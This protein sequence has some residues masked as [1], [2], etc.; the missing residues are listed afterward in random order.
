MSETCFY[1]STCATGGFGC[2]AGGEGAL[3]RFCGHDDYVPCPDASAREAALAESVRSRLQAEVGRVQAEA[4]DPL[5]A[6]EVQVQVEVVHASTYVVSVGT[7]GATTDAARTAA[8][9][10]AGAALLC[11]SSHT[12]ADSSCRVGVMQ[13]FSDAADN[14]ACGAHSACAVLGLTGECCP[15]NAEGAACCGSSNGR[16]RHLDESA[17]SPPL[18]ISRSSSVPL[19][20]ATS[21]LQNNPAAFGSTMVRVGWC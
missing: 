14:T 11:N 7:D 12:I 6:S 3:C 20:P 1:D 18:V 17:S 10:T 15:K 21:A 4:G 19:D 16:R 2:N 5:A 13:V 9:Q 8:V